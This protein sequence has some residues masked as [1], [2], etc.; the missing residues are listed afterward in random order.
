MKAYTPTQYGSFMSLDSLVAEIHFG[1]M[2]IHNTRYEELIELKITMELWVFRI[3]AQTLIK[4]LFKSTSGHDF[5]GAIY[6]LQI[7]LQLL[8]LQ[9]VLL[10][11]LVQIQVVAR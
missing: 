7:T 1:S 5:S 10:L 4:R 8:E 6:L 2:G 11:P 9:L 3:P